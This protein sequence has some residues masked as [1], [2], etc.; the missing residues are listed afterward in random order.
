[1]KKPAV[2]VSKHNKHAKIHAYLIEEVGEGEEFDVVGRLLPEGS[3]DERKTFR[4]SGFDKTVPHRPK[5]GDVY[6]AW[7]SGME[8][9]NTMENFKKYYIL[10]EPTAS[11]E[12][13]TIRL[14]IFSSPV[15]GG[16][17]VYVMDDNEAAATEKARSLVNTVSEAEPCPNWEDGQYKVTESIGTHI[18][19]MPGDPLLGTVHFNLE[20][21]D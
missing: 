14:Y 18:P 3:D 15:S 21:N 16:R 8:S 9:Y 11:Q 4:F 19:F 7:L 12:E 1:M 5:V 13:K 10:D 6:L 2:Y 17:P 20:K